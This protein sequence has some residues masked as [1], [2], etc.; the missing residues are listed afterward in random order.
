MQRREKQRKW[1][2][3]KEKDGEKQRKGKQE[4]RIAKASSRSQYPR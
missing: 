1:V 3:G 2:N 4:R